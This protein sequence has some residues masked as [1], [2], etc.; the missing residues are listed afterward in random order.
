M[1]AILDVIE[2]PQLGPNGRPTRLV[3]RGRTYRIERV[4]DE[5]EAG[6]RW[7]LG[8]SDRMYYHLLATSGAQLEVFQEIGGAR[9]WVVSR[10]QD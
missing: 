10:V 6:G 7:W 3:W 5:W 1:K 8:E 4:R 9:R 2:P